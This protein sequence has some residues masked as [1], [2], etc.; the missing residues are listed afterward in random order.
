[1]LSGVLDPL[2]GLSGGVCAGV[3]EAWAHLAAGEYGAVVLSPAFVWLWSLA[4]LVGGFMVAFRFW[5]R[6]GGVRRKLLSFTARLRDV[7]ASGTFVEVFEDYS[8]DA[9]AAFGLAW[10]EF[11]ESLEI[12]KDGSGPI[13]NPT[14]VSA[15]LN[16]Q[17]IVQP[18][19]ALSSFST[20]PN[21]LTGT[22]ILGTFVGLAAGV[23][24]ASAGLL[25][26]S[27]EEIRDALGTLFSGA[28]LA[29]ITSIVGISC[30]LAFVVIETGLAR[31]L[32]RAVDEWVAELE[33]CLERVTVERVALEQRDL[34]D[35]IRSSFSTFD[36]QLA[37]TVQ[38]SFQQ[39]LTESLGDP[40]TRLIAAVEGLRSDRDD[41]F[42]ERLSTLV[43]RF[44]HDLSGRAGADFERMS[45]VLTELNEHL[46]ASTADLA[47]GRREVRQV[48]GEIAEGIRSSVESGS[49]AAARAVEASA[50][51]IAALLEDQ[52]GRSAASVSA[53]AEAAGTALRDAA[54]AAANE[55]REA[56]QASAAE[57]RRS[58][59][60]VAEE[61]RAAAGEVSGAAQRVALS[62]DAATE[63]LRSAAA[64]AAG[65]IT[66][67]G[68]AA[69]ARVRDVFTEASEALRGAGHLAG[70]A[71]VEGGEGARASLAQGG[72]AARSG[73]D[74]SAT[75]LAASSAT[76]ERSA[77][78]NAE[79]FVR[80]S[81]LVE[82][83]DR[84]R[85][86]AASLAETL[87]GSAARIGS[88][89]DAAR[90]A[91]EQTRDAL[92]PLGDLG[93]DIRRS[94]EMLR[95]HHTAVQAVWESYR[96]RFE[97]VDESVSNVLKE[98]DG[99]L[100]L[101][102]R[103]AQEYFGQMDAKLGEFVQNL[104][105]AVGELTS[106]LED[107][108]AASSTAEDA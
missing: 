108:R 34:L 100:E 52:A 25:A 46:Q 41:R 105:G 2:C 102:R 3:A 49:D 72:Q 106:A 67:A 56:G 26:G 32:H 80:L 57:L 42:T 13:R 59:E 1:M 104:A 101:H 91:A 81:D 95:E 76:L 54:A 15:Y 73:L 39:S 58:A 21:I 86:A 83:L 75:S 40:L 38:R 98:L 77:D 65:D 48:L 29:F 103:H 74:A 44:S 68:E 84:L 24:E 62:V 35:Q 7:S 8:A 36:D 93:E 69:G 51:R 31:G 20:V 53:S 63:G 33:S 14:E 43:D 50:A 19:V 9:K 97:G 99:A 11:E 45:G 90:A 61:S 78:R 87:S 27:Q 12:P 107:H 92:V 70:Q 4:I 18:S 64:A 79:V 60:A 16:D 71:L 17:T 47:A 94:V 23:A 28:S 5:S 55:S 85:G 30:S 96:E 82:R 10:T 6:C 88:G 37:A 22:G 89:A 66:G